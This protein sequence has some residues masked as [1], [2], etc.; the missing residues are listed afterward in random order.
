MPNL[1]LLIKSKNLFLTK[2]AEGFKLRL[3]CFK[4]FKKLRK[5][6]KPELKNKQSPELFMMRS[7]LIFVFADEFLHEIRVK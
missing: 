1:R 4:T 2:K 3:F 7:D 6:I 5:V